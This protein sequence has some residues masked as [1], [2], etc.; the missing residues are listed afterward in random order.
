MMNKDIYEIITDLNDRMTYLNKRIWKH[1]CILFT[2][3]F[4]LIVLLILVNA[5]M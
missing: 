3:G 2:L 1:D 4:L 5:V